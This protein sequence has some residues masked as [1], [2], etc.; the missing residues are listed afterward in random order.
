MNYYDDDALDAALFALPLEEPPANLRASI[1][2]AT[3]YRPAPL[4]A[5]GE[6]AV[7]GAILAVAVWLLAAVIMGGGPLFLQSLAAIGSNA[8]R[9]FGNTSLLL[10][11]AAGGATAIWLSIFPGLQ[12]RARTHE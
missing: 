12:S 11:A 6:L 9:T 8:S 10:W 4:F 3:I 1:F 7:L 5:F 2:A